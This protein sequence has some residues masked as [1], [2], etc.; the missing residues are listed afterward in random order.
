MGDGFSDK[1]LE[2]GAKGPFNQE[3]E[4]EP[5]ILGRRSVYNKNRVLKYNAKVLPLLKKTVVASH[6][7]YGS[8]GD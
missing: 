4:D 8:D 3:D 6:K 7:N 1:I 2:V 5:Y